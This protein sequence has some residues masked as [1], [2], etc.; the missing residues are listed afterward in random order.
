MG[1]GEATGEL[2]TG[3]VRIGAEGIGDVGTGRVGVGGGTGEEV[4]RGELTGKLSVDWLG[5]AMGD[6]GIGNERLGDPGVVEELGAP[7]DDDASE[8]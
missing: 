5:A 3:E 7:E 2:G 1:T 8:D 4:E 6:D